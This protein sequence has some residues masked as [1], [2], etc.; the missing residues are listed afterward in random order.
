MIGKSFILSCEESCDEENEFLDINDSLFDP[1][2]ETEIDG[3]ALPQIDE[4]CSTI[5]NRESSTDGQPTVKPHSSQTPSHVHLTRSWTISM[6]RCG[7]KL[8][9]GIPCYNIFDHSHYS[10]IQDKCG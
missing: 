1:Y 3:M 5:G 4:S 8:N 10:Y 9:N 2:L 7:C 6:K